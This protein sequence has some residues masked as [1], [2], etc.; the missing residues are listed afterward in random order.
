[1][2]DASSICIIGA[3]KVGSS[4]YRR[5][6]QSGYTVGLVGRNREQQVSAVKESDIIL[7]TV[8]DGA[9][10]QLC[11]QLADDFRAGSIIAH[12]SGALNSEELSSAS[13]CH[14]AS[15]HPLNT[16]PTMQAAE[17]V[18][19]KPD[20]GTYLYLEGDDRALAKLTPLFKHAGFIVQHLNAANK[21]DYH[22]ACVFACNYLTVLMDMSLRSADKAGLDR[23]QF[24]RSIRPLIDATLINIGRHGSVDSLSGPIAR[25]DALTI[26]NHLNSLEDLR[27]HYVNLGIHALELARQRGELS[28]EQLDQLAEI[29]Q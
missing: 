15:A 1:M 11:E 13:N 25:G 10:R 14:L 18:L 9:I 17:A 12:C 20:H 29:L 2:T 4:L 23:S 6:K 19:S 26:S 7:L 16:F 8:N 22:I 28:P 5:L 21:T 27:D 3:G 24:W